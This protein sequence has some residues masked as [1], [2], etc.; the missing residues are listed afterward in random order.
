MYKHL[1][2]DGGRLSVTF[3]SHHPDARVPNPKLLALHAACS[4]VVHMSGATEA[5]DELDRNAGAFDESE[6]DP[7]KTSV[8]AFN[9]SSA[10]LPDHLVT[11]FATILKVA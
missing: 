2:D 8:P 5:F 4:R 6:R 11:P 7:E 9:D 3:S 1:R 10:S